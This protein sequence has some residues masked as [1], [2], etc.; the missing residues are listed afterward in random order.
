[1]N[2]SYK[3]ELG[4]RR[5]YED[6]INL[7]HHVSDKHPRMP[8]IDR[9][10]QFSSFAA[11]T[12][13]DDAIEET[14]RLTDKKIELDENTKELLDMRL[15]MIREHMAG[16]PKVTFTYFEPDD[17]KSGGAY[18][19]VT[20]IVK[21]INDFEHKIILDDGIEILIDNIIDIR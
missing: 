3:D 15:M 8:L 12:G 14:A 9:A 16:K 20:G 2:E 5:S 21:K 13:H 7:P 10:A 11:L 18:V 1:M 4:R 19:D 17:K 6:I